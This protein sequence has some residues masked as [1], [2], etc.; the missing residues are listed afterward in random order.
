MLTRSIILVSTLSFVLSLVG[1]ASSPLPKAVGSSDK[2][3]IF[4]VKEDLKT[5][6]GKDE[7]LQGS[8]IAFD[9]D[10]AM[11]ILNGTVKDREQFGWAATIAAGTPGVTSVINRL[12]VEPPATET[13]VP[14]SPAPKKPSSQPQTPDRQPASTSAQTSQS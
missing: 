14:K 12:Q 13:E 3:S 7:R 11:V 2:P 5:R 9:Y 6:L 8:N 10:G 4:K 1:C